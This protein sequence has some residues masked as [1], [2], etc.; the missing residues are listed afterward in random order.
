MSTSR[1][2][3]KQVTHMSY[4]FDTAIILSAGFGSRLGHITQKTPKALVDINGTPILE[5][6]IHQLQQNNITKIIINTHYLSQ[7]I[8]QFLTEKN[9]PEVICL[10]EPEILETGGGVLNALPFFDNHP[11]LVINGDCYIDTEKDNPFQNIF[12]LWSEEKMD[13][14]LSLIERDNILGFNGVENP[15]FEINSESSL[16]IPNPHC[17][18]PSLYYSSIQAVH[19]WI[20]EGW[21]KKIFSMRD[22]WEQAYQ[23]GR[24]YGTVFRGKWGD[25]GTLDSLEIIRNYDKENANHPRT[26]AG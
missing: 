1:T 3:F 5:R 7:Q 4:P 19:P 13:V 18:F 25:M 16:V 15:Y 22:V 20:F 23:A 6:I 10:Y 2:N 24:L 8:H 26:Q 21:G 11:F 14:L 9:F 17:Q 12:D